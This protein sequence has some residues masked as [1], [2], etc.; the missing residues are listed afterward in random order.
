MRIVMW[1]SIFVF[2]STLFWPHLLN[3]HEALIS[4]LLSL[5]LLLIPRLRIFAVIPISALYF[6]LYTTL[7]LTGEPFFSSQLERPI[8]NSNRVASLVDGQDHSIVVEIVSLIS[9]ANRGYYKAKLVEIDTDHLNYKPLLEM[10]WYRPTIDVQ[11]GQKHRFLVKLKPVYGRANPGGFDRQKWSY[12][13][14]VGYQANIK[15]HLEVVDTKV[16]FRAGFYQQV[17]SLTSQFTHQGLLLALSFADKSLIPFKEKKLIRDL[18]ISHLFAISGLHIGLFFSALYLAVQFIVNRYLPAPLMG[19][20]S[21][22]LI[23]FCALLGAW[24]YAYLAGFSLPTQR[25]FLMLM[26]A[27]II[28]SLKRKCAKQDILLL[29]LFLVLVWDPLAVLSLSL[30]LSFGAVVIIMGLFWAFP[31]L[32]IYKKAQQKTGRFNRLIH[33]FKVLLLLQIGLSVLMLPLQLTGFSALS[34]PAIFVNLLA[35]PL[36]SLVI[37]PLV[38][39]ATLSTIGYPPL[40]LLLFTIA[41]KLLSYFFT[42]THLLSDSYQWF[43]MQERQALL[44]LLGGLMLMVWLYFHGRIQQKLGYLFCFILLGLVA[45]SKSSREEAWFVDVID[46]GQGLSVLIRSDQQT[47]LYDTGARYPS[48]FNMVD[49]EISPFLIELGVSKLDHLVI[50]HSDIDH[51]GGAELIEQKVDIGKRWAGEPLATSSNYS[52]CQRGQKWSLGKLQVEVLS[53][54]NLTKNNNNNSCV[55]SVSDGN[56]AILLTG[57]IEKRQEKRLLEELPER[58]NSDILLAPHH[59]SRHSSSDAFIAMVNPQWVVFSA[60]FMNHWGFP[61]PEVIKRYQN[62]AVKMVNSG[63]SGLIRFQIT[64]QAIKM[65]TF[66]ED[67]APY[68]YHRSLIPDFSI[69]QI[70]DKE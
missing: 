45:F 70:D 66:R 7:T 16:T 47:L 51:A 11:A 39:L 58:L 23:N 21:C 34:L 13:E 32:S 19:W 56:T 24:Y 36:F 6:T 65:Q 52:L 64:P 48:G 61:A 43:S 60:G 69:G 62:Q 68:W 67:L 35:V 28:L 59:G 9:E 31:T 8:Q 4:V 14:H 49:S 1:L 15:K 26:V 44:L 18:G 46:V 20:F 30:W 27:V 37:I 41:D 3:V 5:L 25:A 50:S 12:S 2:I 29:V 33:Y 54:T 63:L 38:L 53:P 57:D 10:R 22:R 40:A 55:L 17:Q 42:F